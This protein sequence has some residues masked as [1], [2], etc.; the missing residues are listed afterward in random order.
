VPGSWLN[1]QAGV[2]M[3]VGKTVLFD[4]NYQGALTGRL[5]DD[6]FSAGLAWQF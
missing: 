3:A 2:H 6:F 1:G 4:L 5:H